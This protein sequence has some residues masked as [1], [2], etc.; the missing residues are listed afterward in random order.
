MPYIVS[1]KFVAMDSSNPTEFEKDR[2]YGC[3]KCNIF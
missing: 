2:T 1:H 3:A